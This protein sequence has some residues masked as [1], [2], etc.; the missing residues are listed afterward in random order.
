MS[1][2]A[3]ARMINRT[4]PITTRSV[5]GV[6]NNGPGTCF[7]GSSPFTVCLFMTHAGRYTGSEIQLQWRVRVREGFSKR[8]TWVSTGS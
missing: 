4:S 2:R 8:Q 1:K 5:S 6:Q 3:Y 7:F